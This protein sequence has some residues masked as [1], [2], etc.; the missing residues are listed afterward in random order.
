MFSFFIFFLFSCSAD[1]EQTIVDEE[2]AETEVLEE[3][4]ESET[5]TDEN[6]TSTAEV[7]EE[8]EVKAE[9]ESETDESTST[10]SKT[11]LSIV[12]Q[13]FYING[14]L[15]YEGRFWHGRK[16]EGL[17]MNSRMVQGI[18]DDT[19]SATRQQFAYPDTNT[20]DADRNTDEFIAQMAEWKSK[21]LLSF[22]LNL[23]G[24]SPTG[25][26]NK[27]AWV[28]SAFDAY[29][30]I[31]SSYRKRLERILDEADKLQMVVILGYFYFGQDQELSSE[32]SVINAVD[33]ITYWILEKRY[34]NILVEIN[35]ECNL[36][37]YD[38]A[39]LGEH[40]IHEL[41]QRVK[42]IQRDGKR[43][44]VSTSYSG[45]STPS[46]QVIQNSDYILLHGNGVNEPS[47]MRDIIT[48]TRNVAGGENKP[49]II[50]EDDHYDFDQA[51]YNF[52]AAVDGYVSWGFFDYRKQSETF[53]QGFQS[54][55][56]DWGIN[57]DRKR[58]FF[59]KLQEITGY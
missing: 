7:P 40:R 51:D 53:E 35:N 21:G 19:N 11:Q 28:N 23:Q 54:V 34:E 14:K 1:A 29:G 36:E 56:V 46:K 52:L 30:N 57:S 55:P 10:T 2:I 45:G 26:G 22:T 18:F 4:N 59:D 47:R 27:Q 58:D 16:I 8:S 25:Y 5:L 12:G 20:W 6:A 38:H 32:Q 41:I 48:R 44:L 17:L 24:G 31:K 9:E 50:N 3:I 15:T 33:N 13:Q 37:F 43:L 49:I 42:N 39:I